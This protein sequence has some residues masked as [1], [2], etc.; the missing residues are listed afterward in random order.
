MSD[1]ALS[2][3]LATVGANQREMA[4]LEAEAIRIQERLDA[5]RK[6]NAKLETFVEVYR[7]LAKPESS[8]DGHA[9]KKAMIT[10]AASSIIKKHGAPVPLKELYAAIEESGVEIGTQNPK[11]YLST[12]LNRDD[13]FESIPGAGWG[14]R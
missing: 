13:R 7:T 2:R 10:E 4:Q 12:T 1:E 3:A 14:L 5:I 9:S 11:Q 8:D 6:E